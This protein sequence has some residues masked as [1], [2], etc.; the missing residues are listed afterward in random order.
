MSGHPEHVAWMGGSSPASIHDIGVGE[1]QYAMELY[2]DTLR[3][4]EDYWTPEVASA[5]LHD[6]FWNR[7]RDDAHATYRAAARAEA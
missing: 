6:L 2:F 4:W 7:A 1:Y 3:I 5:R